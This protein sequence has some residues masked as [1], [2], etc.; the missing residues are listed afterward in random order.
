MKPR[1][2]RPT[3][4]G[5]Y[6]F[7]G[8]FTL[9]VERH[10]NVLAHFEDGDYGAST[11]RANWP[12]MPVYVD[13][14]A[15]PVGEY[16]GRVDFLYANPPCAIF[17]PIGVTPKRGREAWKTDPRTAC[18]GKAFALFEGLEARA[19]AHESV[20]RAYTLGRSLVDD[21]TRRA[22]ALGYSVTHI[23]TNARWHGLP[24]ARKRFL[25]V[26]HRAARLVVVP[27]ERVD[28]T[29]R[30]VFKQVREAGYHCPL[31]QRNVIDALKRS[32]VGGSLSQAWMKMHP[33]WDKMRN[34][35]GEVHGRPSFMDGRLPWDGVMGAYTGG[36]HYYHPTKDRRLGI[37]EA[38]AVCGYPQAFKF[39]DPRE[40]EWDSLLARAVMPPVGE[41]IARCVA[42]TLLEPDAAWCDRRVTRVDLRE[43]DKE[44]MD[45][46]DEY[47]DAL[48][49]RSP[50][51]LRQKERRE[52]KKVEPRDMTMA[53]RG[54]TITMRGSKMT[55]EVDVGDARLVVGA[56]KRS[57][58]IEEPTDDSLAGD[59]DRESFVPP[60]PKQKKQRVL[61]TGGE[62][63]GGMPTPAPAAA[64]AQPP[65]A[66]EGSGKYI[67]RVWMT[68]RYT[69]DQIVA[70]VHRHWQGRTTK[71]S[72][73]YYNYKKLIEAGAMDVPPWSVDA[74]AEKKAAKAAR[75]RETKEADAPVVATDAPA[76]ERLTI[77]ERPK[78]VT[79][80][81]WFPR[82]CGSTDFSGH[83]RDG[84]EAVDLVSFSKSGRSLAG[85]NTNGWPWQAFSYAGAA[86][87]LNSYDAV[88]L[89]D[90]VCFAPEVRK[91]GE[92][93]YADVVRRLKVP[94]TAMYHGGIYP[95]KHDDVMDA[96][97]KAPSFCGSLVTTRERQAREKFARW[98]WVKFVTNAYLPYSSERAPK[99]QAA[100][101]RRAVMMTGR[102][103][104]NKGQNAA[105]LMID[106]MGGDVEVW[107]YNATG[108]PSVA[109]L[110]Y[111]M[112]QAMKFRGAAPLVRKDQAHQ[113][114]CANPN[115]KKFYTGAFEATSPKGNAFRYHDE[116]ESLDHIDWSP[117][118]HLSL[119]SPAFG[120][121]LEYVSLD[122]VH[123]GCVAVVP[124]FAVAAA[125]YDSVVTA[126]YAGC[127]MWARK[128]SSEIT[129]K[130]DFDRAGVAAVISGLF[131]KRDRELQAIA[132]RQLA[133]V[134]TKHDPAKFRASF[135]KALQGGGK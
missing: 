97:L 27:I 95:S 70:L 130:V 88:I 19:F 22:L 132:D 98:P 32:P 2:T 114:S 109:W 10:F 20:P 42:A 89:G 53:V 61:K 38:K 24:Q 128:K 66:G 68:G 110:L 25:F 125:K 39:G 134:S 17:S 21:F 107:G 62:L 124:E 127:T 23:F 6:I 8:G 1:A 113:P 43:L 7:A 83:L 36:H 9:G 13:R 80:V 76:G 135:V 71:R 75:E 56:E 47:G 120:D 131:K 58:P 35:K 46:T 54:G 72:D 99:R 65:M 50:H 33:R 69:P 45:I 85:W 105:L 104:S 63:S 82:L 59:G 121:T 4:A 64:G 118:V 52:M 133:E 101:R 93:Y 77:T 84:V 3:A 87:K 94:F 34:K 74:P 96:I 117:W 129:G 78:R 103:M 119:P 41:F 79:V 48:R 11:A 16:C 12:Q 67:Q 90:L 37:N 122:A 44:P 28:V 31:K 91:D 30:D 40:K 57:K 49:V 5:T 116:Y 108:M 14:A 51:G 100:K 26:A 60:E 86:E 111:E 126:P 29:V 123:A 92:P 115:K 55:I 15:W 81:D 18:W 106:Q 102:L 112:S 73:V